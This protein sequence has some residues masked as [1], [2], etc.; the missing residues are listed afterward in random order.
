[1]GVG[2]YFWEEGGGLLLDHFELVLLIRIQ[3]MTPINRTPYPPIPW[4]LNLLVQV[5]LQPL[6]PTDFQ[7]FH[8]LHTAFFHP[9]HCP[10]AVVAGQDLFRGGE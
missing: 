7:T 5:I 10:A 2:V 1:M 8:T 9:Q 3:Q 6:K 4:L